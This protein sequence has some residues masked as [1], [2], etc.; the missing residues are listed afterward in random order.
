VYPSR[1]AHIVRVVPEVG[2]LCRTVSPHL[3]ITT[4]EQVSLNMHALTVSL[5]TYNASLWADCSDANP[6][7]NPPS[8]KIAFSG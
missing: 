5:I 8:H 1:I 2:Y 7:V 6:P 4:R 3:T